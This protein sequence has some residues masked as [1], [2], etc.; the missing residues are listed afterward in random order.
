VGGKFSGMNVGDNFMKALLK[1]KKGKANIEIR[2]IPTPK[3][4][5]GEVLIKVK[6]A[7]LCHSDIYLYEWAPL[8]DAFQITFPVVMGHEFS[9]VIAEIG[10]G[11]SRVKPGDTVMVNPVLSCGHCYYCQRGMIQP[12]VGYRP[13]LGFE[14][15][16]GF[17]EYV[18]IKENNVYKLAPHV[19]LEIAALAEPFGVPIHALGKVP[20]E[21]G[22][23]LLISGPGPIGLMT[24]ILALKSGASRVYISGLGKDEKRLEMAKKLGGIPINI[25]KVDIKEFILDET[26]GF[27]VDVA[28]EASG[29]SRAITDDLALLRKG[30]RLGVLGVP[31]ESASFD[32]QALVL[33]EKSIIGVRSYTIDTWKRC[34]EIFTNQMVDLTPIITHRLPLEEFEKGIKYV[35]ESSALK[36]L[37]VP[38]L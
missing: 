11:V 31:K 37:L 5:A 14:L 21:P 38:E 23:I 28:F 13:L 32:P 7:G 35:E 25:E 2:E 18:V 19:S 10:A 3:P 22:E 6:A 34:Q 30:G 9:G 36:V 20:I 24:Q 33:T 17:G 15:N 26:N 8:V 27:G 1:T 16:G 4:G 12:C 29:N